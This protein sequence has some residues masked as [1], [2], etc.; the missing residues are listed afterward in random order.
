M[1]R[2]G[3][4]TKIDA[5]RAALY[6]GALEDFT[7]RRAAAVAALTAS[8]D[9]EGAAALKATRRPTRAAWLVDR[10]S[11]EARPELFAAFAAADALRHAEARDDPDALR[12]AM[13]E[14]SATH[15]RLLTVAR[16]LLRDA[17]VAATPETLRRVGQTLRAAEVDRDARAQVEAGLVTTELE[18]TL[19]DDATVRARTRSKPAPERSTRSAL[20][21]GDSASQARA[22]AKRAAVEVARLEALRRA[23]RGRAEA[24]VRAAKKALAAAEARVTRARAK[25]DAAADAL[26]KAEG[27]ARDARAAA[28]AAARALAALR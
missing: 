19:P 25:V 28:T 5:A 1:A 26:A 22:A 23:E 6:A 10:L 7:A 9:R 16:S 24:A 27:A 17:G 14:R 15:A 18:A 8:G 11:R 13:R 3:S 20:K 4:G 21:Q 12:A 2:A